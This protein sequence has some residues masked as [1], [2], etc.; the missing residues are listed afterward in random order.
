M[1][2]SFNIAICRLVFQSPPASLASRHVEDLFSPF[3]IMLPSGICQ[4]LPAS[5]RAGKLYWHAGMAGFSSRSLVPVGYSA[6]KWACMICLARTVT[7]SPLSLP[8]LHPAQKHMDTQRRAHCIF[9]M[10]EYKASRKSSTV[11]GGNQ[12]SELTEILHIDQ[13]ITSC[14][15]PYFPL[16]PN[17]VSIHLLISWQYRDFVA[18]LFSLEVFYRG[19]IWQRSFSGT[20]GGGFIY[21]TVSSMLTFESRGLCVGFVW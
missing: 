15:W 7:I 1:D 13:V 16:F 5:Q 11:W 18:L 8:F 2:I 21:N 4:V 9:E 6:A 3:G 20:F 17:V 12:I 19:L 10:R 14:Q